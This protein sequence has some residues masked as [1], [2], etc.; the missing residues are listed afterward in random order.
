LAR[1]SV[2]RA[3]AIIHLTPIEYR[4]LA[5]LVANGGRMLTRRQ[6]LRAVRGRPPMPEHSLSARLTDGLRRKLEAGPEMPKHAFL[7]EKQGF[8]EIATAAFRRLS[9]P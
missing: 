2:T 8:R 9:A 5:P 7:R 4:L 3:G 1:R 6:I